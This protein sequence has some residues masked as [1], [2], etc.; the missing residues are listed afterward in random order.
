MQTIGQRIDDEPDLDSL[1]VFGPA[2][3]VTKNPTL[4][5]ESKLIPH[6]PLFHAELAVAAIDGG[7]AHGSHERKSAISSFVAPYS[8]DSTCGHITDLTS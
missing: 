4:L 3:Q 6:H 7:A 5:D 1:L 2:L 8:P